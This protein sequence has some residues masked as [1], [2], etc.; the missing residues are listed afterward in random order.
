MFMMTL[1][2]WNRA[3]INNKQ[4]IRDERRFMSEFLCLCS[5]KL[6]NGNKIYTSVTRIENPTKDSKLQFT[7]MKIVK[8]AMI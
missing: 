8:V 3:I 1:V 4:E 2:E 6:L 5:C 7:K